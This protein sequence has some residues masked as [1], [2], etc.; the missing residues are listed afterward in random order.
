MIGSKKDYLVFVDPKQPLDKA[1]MNR[2]IDP[3]QACLR[4]PT[5]SERERFLKLFEK[6]VK[7]AGRVAGVLHAGGCVS[8]ARCHLPLRTGRGNRRRRPRPAAP[9]IADSL[10][11]APTDERPNGW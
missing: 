4:Q 10:A 5:Q 11:F 1:A 7:E 2:A 8:R 3:V 9:E 6:T